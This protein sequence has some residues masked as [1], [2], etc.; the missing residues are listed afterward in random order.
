MR[1]LTMR[2]SSRTSSSRAASTAS[3]RSA[4]RSATSRIWRSRRSPTR[5]R[6][7]S[8]A[9][10]SCDRR[11]SPSRRWRRPLKLIVRA[12]AG[13][14]TIDVKAATARGIQRRELPGQERDR[15]RRADVGAAARARSPHSRQRRRPARRH[16]EQEGVLEGARPVRGDARPPR[17]RRIAREM[18]DAR[19]RLR[20]ARSCLWSRRFDG[21]GSAADGRR[22]QE[23]GL[24]DVARQ[25]TIRLAPSPAEVAARSRRAEHAPRARARDE[26]AGERRRA[27]APQA[28]QLRS[29]TP[30]A[31]KSSITTRWRAAIREKKLRVALDVF[32][33]EPAGADRRRS[34]IRSSRSPASIGTHHIGASTDQAQEA[35]AA[36]TVRIVKTF[37][38][39]DAATRAE[40][41]STCNCT[42]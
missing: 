18:I 24:E 42:C 20:H 8:R 4:A 14:N 29:S 33:Q 10:S 37:M 23:L 19:R 5:S 12:G 39:D 38:D 32:A 13:V 15:R 1:T 21:A 25:V 36:E 26:A 28:R 11:R 2:V 17:R 22:G 9:R 16:V 34:P 41:R 6:R 31:A 35:I 27:R 7:S 40:R 3:R 30:R